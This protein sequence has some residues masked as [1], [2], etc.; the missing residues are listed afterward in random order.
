MERREENRVFRALYL[1]AI[2]FVVDGHI[3]LEGELFNFGGLFRYYSFHM[4]LFAF[5]S[6]Y[7][8]DS[9]RGYREALLRDIRQ[10]LVPLYLWNLF[11]GILMTALRRFLGLQYGAPLSAY[12]LLLAPITDGEQF[13]LNGA[14]WFI[15]AMFLAKLVYRT[16]SLPFG[17]KSMVP[18]LF[19]LLLGSLCVYGISHRQIPAPLYFLTRALV[20]LPGYAAGHLYRER[21]EK[22]DRLPTLPWLTGIVLL[23]I[24]FTTLVPE[25]A[26]LLSNGTYFLCGPIG[27]YLGGALAIAFYLRIARL[28]APLIG[29]SRILLFCSRNTF[30]VMMHHRLGFLCLNI[31]FLLLNWFHLGAANF[32]LY[33]FRAAEYTYAPAGHPEWAVLYLLA[34]I[35]LSLAIAGL[36]QRAK[37]RLKKPETRE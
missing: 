17:S 16:L 14:A 5:G 35:A 34:G 24:L 10:L 31:I 19:S 20:L 2:F 22:F 33:E 8:Y 21:L 1:M 29:K 36:M 23:R 27:V 7:F 4:L 26:Y 15:G 9:T 12:S 11:Y 18:F 6:G 3:P 28:I 30:S 13:V 25:N 32:H 37:A